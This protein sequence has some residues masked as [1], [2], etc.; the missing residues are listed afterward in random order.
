[1]QLNS[2]V[3]TQRL[4]R[5]LGTILALLLTIPSLTV[6][7]SCRGNSTF[8]TYSQ[9]TGI[10]HFS[11][12]YPSGY[13]EQP[14]KVTDTLI[15]LAFIDKSTST[16]DPAQQTWMRVDAFIADS[17][18]PDAATAFDNEMSTASILSADLR[19]IEQL[20]IPV[21]GVQGTGIAM[22]YRLTDQGSPFVVR[23]V[24]FDKNGRIYSVHVGSSPE[25]AEAAKSAFDRTLK[26]FKILK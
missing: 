5:R 20:S 3:K 16:Q 22:Q 17:T 25:N 8:V 21:A 14:P 24:Y 9:K 6:L 19:T 1:M 26:T 12:D 10:A 13:I 7:P 23:V 4:F 15:Q 18:T 11:F 2:K